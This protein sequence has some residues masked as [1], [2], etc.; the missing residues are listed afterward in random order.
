[1]LFCLFCLFVFSFE[2]ASPLIQEA[3]SVLNWW[4]SLI[5]IYCAGLLNAIITPCW[6]FAL[7]IKGVWTF[8]V[9]KIFQRHIERFRNWLWRDPRQHCMCLTTSVISLHLFLVEQASFFILFF[10]ISSKTLSSSKTPCS[11]YSI[12]TKACHFVIIF[13]SNC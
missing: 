13:I 6:P 7:L 8:P 11:F 12:V 5:F 4:K 10:K 3:F 1:M 9:I 2:D